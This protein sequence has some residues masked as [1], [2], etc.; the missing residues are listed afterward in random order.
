[1]N[2]CV[3]KEGDL[4]CLTGP[5]GDMSGGSEEGYGLY[6]RDTRFL[7]EMELKVNGEPPLLLSSHLDR[8]Y[9][10]KLRLMN[11]TKDVGAMEIVRERYIHKGSLHE[12]ITVTNFFPDARPADIDMLFG[13]DFQDMFLVRRYRTGEV[14]H[15]SQTSYDQEAITLQYSGKDGMERFIHIQWDS[16]PAEVK[17]DGHVRFYRILQPR[18]SISIHFMITPEWETLNKP[19][20]PPFA[21][22][23]AALTTSYWAWT[24]DTMT[25]ETDHPAFQ[26]VF[27]R[28]VQDLKM[29]LSD[30]GYG[31]MPT[32]GLPWFAAPFGR[33]SLI[34]SLYMLMLQPKVSQA[35][36]RT[37]AAWQGTQ[38][39]ATRDEQPGKIMHEMRFGELVATGQSPFGPYFGTVDATPLFLVVLAEYVKWTGDLELVKELTPA[40]SKALAW[41]DENSGQYGGFLSYHQEAEQ[42]FPNQG[43]K[44]SP[45]CIVHPSGELA[46]SP[47]ALSEVQG[48]VY[49]A[50]WQLAAIYD[51]LGDAKLGERLRQEARQLQ[52]QFEARYWMEDEQYYAIALER[53]RNPVH[54]VTSN[55]GHLLFCEL[56]GTGRAAK[57]AERLGAPDMNGGFGIRTMSTDADGYYPMSYHNGSVWPHDNGFILLGLSRIGNE[58]GAVQLIDSLLEASRSFAD[59]RFPELFCGYANEGEGVVPYP[60]TCSPQA[61]SAAVSIVIAQTAL[62][63]FPDA[64]SRAIKLNPAL[65]DGMNRLKIER[66]PIGE[67]HL[68]IEVQ[69]LTTNDDLH[70]NVLS[71]TTGYAVEVGKGR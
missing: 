4:F 32:A 44:D 60:T 69:R 54:S 66:I 29:L 26:R 46:S 33:D 8:S 17:E 24:E 62:G 2:N 40:V 28:S 71:N 5:S 9:Y 35:T 14:G 55:P 67:G 13:A 25:V 64:L 61:W 65:P 38:Y 7:S 56:P 27:S 23:L 3:M 21:D 37:L 43:W 51:R 31:E 63:L 20:L 11:Q 16:E 6:T 68:S 41:I 50:K 22:G 15:I 34:T 57:V 53:D 58:A 59:A 39:N 30:Y 42:G 49:Y 47:I 70:V 52:E 45:N 10:T 19:S 1:M 48:Y 18:E 36:L 12:Q